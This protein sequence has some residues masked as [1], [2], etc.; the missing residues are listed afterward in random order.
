MLGVK[1]KTGETQQYGTHGAGFG[2]HHPAAA[3]VGGLYHGVHPAHLAAANPYYGVHPAH[4]AANPYYGLNGIHYP[5]SD[6]YLGKTHQATHGLV[7]GFGLSLVDQHIACVSAGKLALEKKITA[8]GTA[9]KP[10]PEEIAESTRACAPLLQ[11]A[12]N[13]GWNHGLAHG[14]NGFGLMGHAPHVTGFGTTTGQQFSL[15]NSKDT[16]KLSTS[17]TKGA[18]ATLEAATPE[19]QDKAEVDTVGDATTSDAT[20]AAT[21]SSETASASTA[22]DEKSAADPVK[23]EADKSIEGAT[24]TTTFLSLQNKARHPAFYKPLPHLPGY[25]P[26]HGDCIA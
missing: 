6:A 4:L 10:T 24:G 9:R 22:S 16:V 1:E 12:Y 17:N 8:S 20:I 14:T 15:V 7:G 5:G 23:E 2:F 3:F 11:S 13:G 26:R 25:S 21:Q 18:T 19:K